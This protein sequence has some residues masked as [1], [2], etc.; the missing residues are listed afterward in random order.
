MQIIGTTIGYEQISTLDIWLVSKCR[1][2][3]FFL[4]YM[5]FHVLYQGTLHNRY[6]GLNDAISKLEHKC[7]NKRM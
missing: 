7:K 6:L 4:G 5:M 2:K 1:I 3:S